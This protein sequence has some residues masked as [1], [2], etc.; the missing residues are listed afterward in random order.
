M[1]RECVQK[2]VCTQGGDV[3]SCHAFILLKNTRSNSRLSPWAITEGRIQLFAMAASP[4]TAELWEKGDG[5]LRSGSK[6]KR[7]LATVRV[8]ELGLV[9]TGCGNVQVLNLNQG[10][11]CNWNRPS[12]GWPCP[13]S[14][15]YTVSYLWSSCSHDLL[16][17]TTSRNSTFTSIVQN[18]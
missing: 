8:W 6:G 4:H 2:N 3:S 10:R 9:P 12:L 14:S 1:T 5:R 13:Q 15:N 16:K 7:I 11:V 17:R 18:H